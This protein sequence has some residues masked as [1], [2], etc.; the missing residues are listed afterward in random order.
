M[1]GEP[2]SEI[3]IGPAQQPNELRPE[4]TPCAVEVPCGK[5]GAAAITKAGVK[6]KPASLEENVKAVVSKVTLGEADAGIVY[7]TD[8][9]AAGSTAQGVAIANASDPDLVASYP[10]AVTTAPAN[11]EVA[12]AWV[13]YV[14]S[15]DGQKILE[16]YG[17]QQ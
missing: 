9:K 13:D 15:E 11:T 8:V 3:C 4:C 17:F 12:N 6:A 10:I 1:L 2:S 16:K 5:Y 7:V 14:V